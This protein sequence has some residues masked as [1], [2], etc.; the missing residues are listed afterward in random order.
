MFVVLRYSTE[1]TLNYASVVG[2]SLISASQ[3]F[4]PPPT[5]ALC[6]PGC[7]GTRSVGQAGLK[8]QRCACLCLPGAGIKGVHHHV[9]V[10]MSSFKGLGIFKIHLVHAGSTLKTSVIEDRDLA[11]HELYSSFCTSCGLGMLLWKPRIF[12]LPTQF[13][14]YM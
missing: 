4:T 2:Y 6:S 8:T 10:C 3:A 1:L 11:K 9:R 13:S 7:S 12:I 5:L 14:S